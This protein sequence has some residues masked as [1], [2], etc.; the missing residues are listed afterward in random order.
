MDAPGSPPGVL[1]KNPEVIR[2]NT[3]KSG[4]A[5][6]GRITITP[7]GG[8]D[9]GAGW[10]AT[11]MRRNAWKTPARRSR[12]AK[13][14][15]SGSTGSVSLTPREATVSSPA[16]RGSSVA[17][18]TISSNCSGVISST[19]LFPVACSYTTKSPRYPLPLTPLVTSRRIGASSLSGKETVALGKRMNRIIAG[20]SRIKSSSIFP[21]ALPWRVLGTLSIPTGCSS[22]RNAP[23]S[24]MVAYW[25][26]RKV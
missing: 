25:E 7:L 16:K 1:V 8:S 14:R 11:W 6:G 24:G 21:G 26:S 5:P 13:G 22:V 20:L 15:G 10:V 9:G 12:I 23:S 19:P 4:N 3:P 2:K 18:L 17:V